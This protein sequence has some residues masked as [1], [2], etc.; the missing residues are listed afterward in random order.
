MQPNTTLIKIPNP[1]LLNTKTLR[2]FYPSH[3]TTTF[4][5]TQWVSL[6]LA[7]QYA[8]HDRASS[9]VDPAPRDKWWPFILTLPR[10]FPTVPLTWS[11]GRR[12]NEELASAFGIDEDDVSLRERKLDP[13]LRR[14]QEELLETMPPSVRVRS[15]EVETRFRKDWE[16][17]QAEWKKHCEATPEKDSL[18][19]DGFALGWLNTNTRCV[20]FNVGAIKA[21]NLTLAPVIDMVSVFA[22]SFVDRG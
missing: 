1:A 7:L 10:T 15:E 18:C 2:E 3:F 6:H 21:N 20:Y 5:A 22:S 17:V 8:R 9:P 12:T 16:K 13:K 19:F 14:W 4:S 11:I